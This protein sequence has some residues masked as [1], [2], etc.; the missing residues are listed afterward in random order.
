MGSYIHGLFDLPAFRRFAFAMGGRRE[1]FG[2]DRDHIED[3][4]ENLDLLADAFREALDMERFF[5]DFMEVGT[6]HH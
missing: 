6:R 3:V 5:T 1:D 4:E 2:N